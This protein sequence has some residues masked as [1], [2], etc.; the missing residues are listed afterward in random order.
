MGRPQTSGQPAFQGAFPY[1]RDRETEARERR[2]GLLEVGRRFR[3]GI[4]FRLA[5]SV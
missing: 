4:E 5:V 1:T 3:D 2:R